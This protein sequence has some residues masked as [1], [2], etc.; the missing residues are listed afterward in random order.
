MVVRCLLLASTLCSSRVPCP[1][2]P[3]FSGDVLGNMRG[4]AAKIRS[5]HSTRP[6]RN[7]PNIFVHAR[8]PTLDAVSF[9]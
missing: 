4:G 8:H 5:T 9:V 6:A 3:A 2:R 1:P 7:P